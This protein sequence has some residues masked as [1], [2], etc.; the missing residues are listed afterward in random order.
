M[1][2][3]MVFIPYNTHFISTTYEYLNPIASSYLVTSYYTSGV[4]VIDASNPYN[5]QEVAFFD[6]SPNYSGSEFEGCWGAY[7]YLPS[8][9][10]LASDQ[11]TGL[12]ILEITG[13]ILGCT[14]E[15][16]SNYNPDA[17]QDDGSCLIVGCTDPVAE[18]Y[19]PEANVEYN[20][21]CEYLCD[22]FFIDSPSVQTEI[23]A[24]FGETLTIEALGEGD[25]F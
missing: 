20:D 15:D 9:L 23:V 13:P 6:T 2:V 25:I 18:N 14:N 5:L 7:P 24:N 17:N 22:Q 10:I 3:K 16:A 12:H 21:I 8:G 1:I 4:T 19:N 11:Q